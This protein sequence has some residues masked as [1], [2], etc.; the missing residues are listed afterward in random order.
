MR[1]S[2][3]S[4][5]LTKASLFRLT[6]RMA[7]NSK[8]GSRGSEF[9]RWFRPL[10]D[11]LHELGAAR[12]RE[13]SDWVAE[14][15]QVPTAQREALLKSGEERFHNQVQFARQY[16]V[17]EGLIDG[18]KKGIWS[19]TP[20]GSRTRLT[21]EE[22]RTICQKWVKFHAS[23]RA[24]AKGKTEVDIPIASSPETVELEP[25]E[26]SEDVGLLNVLRGL[27]PTGFEHFCRHLLLAYEFERVTVTK[28]SGD[29]G[30]DGIGILQLNPMVSSVVVFQCKRYKR[31]VGREDVSLLRSDAQQRA[32]KAIFITTGSFT[33][34]AKEEA[35]R[36]IPHIELIDGEQLVAM[37]EAKQIGM[38][39]RVVFDID[40]AF[41]APFR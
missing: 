17:W 2:T 29:D 8:S 41:F 4:I 20:L 6:P 32:D 25:E 24:R 34:Q 13:A 10:I 31:S 35:V 19:L 3:A 14:K 33:R 36:V 21:D 40:H 22:A 11:C 1:L 9:V 18:S 23:A 26:R 7:K 38:T 15:E 27:S 5:G 16:L 39:P 28:R 30:I 12:P 37:C